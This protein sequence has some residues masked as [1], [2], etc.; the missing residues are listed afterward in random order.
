MIANIT[1]YLLF[2]TKLPHYKL[3]NSNTVF[4]GFY[5]CSRII[6]RSV[7]QFCPYSRTFCLIYRKN[8]SMVAKRNTPLADV[9]T[10]SCVF[11]PPFYHQ[12]LS[13]QH[14]P[15]LV[16]YSRAHLRQGL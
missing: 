1:Y 11:I 12:K 6:G 4:M 2:E 3:T 10:T 5:R 16:L 14:H 7:V 9:I 8:K 13:R 15:N